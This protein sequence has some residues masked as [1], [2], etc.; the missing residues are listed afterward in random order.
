LINF[1]V[2]SGSKRV[3][4]LSAPGEIKI[5]GKAGSFRG[6]VGHDKAAYKKMSI[7]AKPSDSPALKM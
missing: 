1:F 7:P 3:S 6:V 2:R 4:G 5:F